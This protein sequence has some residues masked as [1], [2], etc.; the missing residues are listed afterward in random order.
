MTGRSPSPSP[1]K[2]WQEDNDEWAWECGI[3]PHTGWN[4]LSEQGARREAE[5]HRSEH[6]ALTTPAHADE[7]PEVSTPA[8]VSS[9]TDGAT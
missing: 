7:D 4:L 2:V 3:C 6:H 5:R 1:C 9:A 8:R